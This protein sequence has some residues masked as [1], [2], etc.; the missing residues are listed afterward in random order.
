RKSSVSDFEPSW[1]MYERA[2]LAG[3]M[4]LLD[5]HREVLGAALKTLGYSLNSTDAAQIGEAA[6]LA[7][8]WK[9][10]IARFD[11]EG[12]KAG[13]ASG[14]FWVVHGFGGDVQQVIDDNGTDDIV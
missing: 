10:N 13:I 12:Y 9:R 1:R 11:N 4:T 3:R 5:D 6:D 8:E 7:I 14:E 2:D